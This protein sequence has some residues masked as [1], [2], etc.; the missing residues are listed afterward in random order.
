MK[1]VTPLQRTL[2]QRSFR[3]IVRKSDLVAN[4]L[5]K[6]LFEIDPACKMLFECD[7]HWQGRKLMQM[8]AIV[9][10]GLDTLETTVPAIQALGKRHLEYGIKPGDYH[11]VGESLIFAL[12]Q[13]MGD[14]F[15]PEV[16]DAWLAVYRFLSEAAMLEV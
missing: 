7:M 2:V 4:L 11:S 10:V 9:V 8:L 13:S 14:D 3:K 5:Y 1:T 12:E 6:K 16:R 15:T